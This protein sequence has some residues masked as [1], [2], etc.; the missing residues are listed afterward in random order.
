MT[1]NEG[2][3]HLRRRHLEP[4]I[5]Q[6]VPPTL[7]GFVGSWVS[8]IILLYCL[9]RCFLQLLHL[10]FCM[11]N[12]PLLPTLFFC[13]AIFYIHLPWTYRLFLS[14]FS[15]KAL[16]TNLLK[17]ARAMKFYE[18]NYQDKVLIASCS[19]PQTSKKSYKIIK[20]T[21]SSQVKSDDK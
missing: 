13:M 12:F 10:H 18:C 9:T 21:V 8:L 4:L 15:K 6:L 20:A 2:A 7:T 1:V 17:L 19:R 14:F 3:V 5:P 16:K 11:I